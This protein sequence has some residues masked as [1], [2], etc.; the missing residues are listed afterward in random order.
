M[1]KELIEGLAAPITGLIG[2]FVEDKDKRN[3]LAVEVGRMMSQAAEH[4]DAYAKALLEEKAKIIRAEA[5]GHSWLQRNWRPL[6]MLWFAVLLG[7]YWFGVTP[8]NLTEAVVVKLFELLKLGIG[9][10]VVGRSVEKIAPQLAD[11]WKN[12]G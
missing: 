1:L 5:T 12:R 7:M 8:P 6:M 2:K 3:E 4:A 10:Y 11:A 9:G